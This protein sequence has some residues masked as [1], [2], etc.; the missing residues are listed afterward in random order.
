MIFSHF[1]FLE[2]HQMSQMKK[3]KI[4]CVLGD[5]EMFWGTHGGQGSEMALF[6]G[7]IMSPK[8]IFLGVID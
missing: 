7:D 8:N 5:M 6:L 2:K 3:Y 1:I 4:Q